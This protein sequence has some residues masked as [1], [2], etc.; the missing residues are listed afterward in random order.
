MEPLLLPRKQ[1]KRSGILCRKS[2][3]GQMLAGGM[4]AD[5][6]LPYLFRFAPF[7]NASAASYLGHRNFSFFDCIA[8]SKNKLF[9]LILTLATNLTFGSSVGSIG[10]FLRLMSCNGASSNIA[11][12]LPLI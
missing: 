2:G 9:L 8:G 10:S 5:I 7:F 6:A 1:Q 12:A 11:I 3:C 4:E